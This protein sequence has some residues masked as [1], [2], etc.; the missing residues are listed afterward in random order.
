MQRRGPKR[1]IVLAVALALGVLSCGGDDGSGHPASDPELVKQAMAKIE[2]AAAAIVDPV[3]SRYLPG[4]KRLE[5]LCLSPEEA[6]QRK[7]GPEFIQCQVEAFSTPSRKRRES[8]Y[9]EGEAW[10]VPVAPDGT[11]GEPL[12]AEG[13][14]IRDFLLN[15]NRLGCS[16]GRTDQ[17]RCRVPAA[18]PAG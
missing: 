18:A 6:R 16:V 15:D 8:V 12:I 13:Y 2:R 3:R 5:V 11:L 10:R 17:V 9:I 4:E 14:R 7:V 1:G